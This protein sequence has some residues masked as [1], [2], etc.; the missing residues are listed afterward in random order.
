M[1]EIY[2][3]NLQNNWAKGQSEGR[4]VRWR[5]NEGSFD[6]IQ[7]QKSILSLSLCSVS[8]S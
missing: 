7:I 2:N 8:F 6:E 1:G 5:K 4:R 3:R